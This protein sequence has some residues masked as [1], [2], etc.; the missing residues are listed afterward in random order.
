[1]ESDETRDK[2][3]L[4]V[5]VG[6]EF[7]ISKP[8]FVDTFSGRVLVI[9]IATILSTA[10]ISLFLDRDTRSIKPETPTITGSTNNKP[11]N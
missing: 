1:M 11:G 2:P 10:I 9:V 5:S 6:R 7:D 8:R 4:R 3:P